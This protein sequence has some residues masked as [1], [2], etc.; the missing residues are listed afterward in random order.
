[1]SFRGFGSR[2][3]NP[4]PLLTRKTFLICAKFAV[5]AAGFGF[6]ELMYLSRCT[7]GFLNDTMLGR[8]RPTQAMTR[9]KKKHVVLEQTL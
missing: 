5:R 4:R 8:Y 7:H 3:D 1:L 9:L 2:T 6:L